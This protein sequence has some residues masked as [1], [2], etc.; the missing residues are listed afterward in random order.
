VD[1]EARRAGAES[2]SVDNETRREGSE[3]QTIRNKVKGHGAPPARLYPPLNAL[4]RRLLDMMLAEIVDPAPQALAYV[5]PTREGHGLFLGLGSPMKEEELPLTIAT[6][7]PGDLV[8]RSDG[9]LVPMVPLVSFDETTRTLWL[10]N[11]AP[12]PLVPSCTA[13]WCR[14]AAT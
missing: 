14:V 8:L 11:D 13:I 2:A 9:V 6:L 10:F 4:M 12:V 1:D 5:R 3:P 7:Q